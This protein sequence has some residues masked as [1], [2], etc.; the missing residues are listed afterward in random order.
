M[1]FFFSCWLWFARRARRRATGRSA[2]QAGR[3]AIGAQRR[4]RAVAATSNARRSASARSS[5]AG[6]GA[7]CRNGRRRRERS[8]Q[9]GAMPA[10]S[11]QA[12]QRDE[13]VGDRAAEQA[14]PSCAVSRERPAMRTGPQGAKRPEPQ[15]DQRE[16]DRRPAATAPSAATAVVWRRLRRARHPAGRSGGPGHTSAVADVTERSAAECRNDGDGAGWRSAVSCGPLH[17][18]HRRPARP[19]TYRTQRF[20]AD[21]NAGADGASGA[22]RRL[23]G[24][25]RASDSSEARRRAGARRAAWLIEGASP[26]RE[27][28]R[29]L[30]AHRWL[31]RIPCSLLP[32]T[33]SL[34]HPAFLA[35]AL[36]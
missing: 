9:G 33:T 11:V 30:E 31:G 12:F 8:L 1:R 35:C 10:A 4:A 2:A 7:P 29:D 24:G 18:T 14:K 22:T 5:G 36:Q 6:T 19:H 32:A 28:L 21:A 16:R 13:M 15:G 23:G 20:A 17:R 27:H 3:F 34:L 26:T 25:S